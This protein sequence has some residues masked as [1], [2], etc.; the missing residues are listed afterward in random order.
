MNQNKVNV[1]IK[2]A[3]HIACECSILEIKGAGDKR[4]NQARAVVQLPTGGKAWTASSA[5]LMINGFRTLGAGT[6]Q[7]SDPCYRQVQ[8]LK[9]WKPGA[10]A[11]VPPE[12]HARSDLM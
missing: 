5:T 4:N 9:L 2:V 6:S 11:V 8:I 7:G 12:R 10:L 1:D 3:H